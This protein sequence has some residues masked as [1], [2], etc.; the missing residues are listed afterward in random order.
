MN[1]PRNQGTPAE[2]VKVPFFSIIMPV[3][4]AASYI[5]ECLESILSQDFEDWE[6]IIVDDGSTDDSLSIAEDFRR[7][8]SRIRTYTSPMNSGGA[9]KP[10]LRAA[11]I[12]SGRY[13]VTIDADDK[14]DDNYLHILYDRINA[15][16]ADL[17]LTEMWKHTESG[18]SRILPLESIDTSRIYAG[19]DL[20]A[21]TLCR[22]SISM[23][24]FAVR[25]ETYLAADSRISDDDKKSIFAD[26]LLSRWVLFISNRAAMCNAAYHYRDNEASV[27]HVNLPRLIKSRM[28]TSDSLIAMTA[29]AFGEES[30]TY[31]MSLDN[32]FRS[33]IGLLRL[34][35][36]S[37]L[38][39]REKRASVRTI[40]DA[41]RGFDISRLKGHVSPRYLALMRL[42][43]PMARLALRIIDPFIN[44]N[45]GF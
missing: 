12:A 10:R 25:R 36:S 20:V 2:N 16:G 18:P 42:P 38:S 24:G 39:G 6:A 13:L 14:V 32:K 31:T 19:K 8:D 22:W 44:M 5:R 1:E 35:S 33:A 43:M 30:P 37:K 17:V 41:M 23:N 28:Q 27:T 7:A 4:N 21:N 29:K 26:E 40:S 34:I 11:N 45:H 9:Y 15:T 3:Y